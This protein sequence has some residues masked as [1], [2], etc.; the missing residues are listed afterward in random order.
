MKKHRTLISLYIYCTLTTEVLSA[1]SGGMP[2]LNPEFWFS[3]IFWLIITFGL[4]FFVLS[5]FILPNISSNLENRKS[6]ILNNIEKADEQRKESEVKLKEFE[7]IIN[8]SKVQAKNI[9]NDTKKKIS[10][11][12]NNKKKLLEEEINSEIVSMEKEINELKKRSPETINQIAVSTSSDLLKQI[13]GADVNKSNISAIV[14]D[15]SK[16]EK[17]RY[18]GI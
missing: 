10:N 7:K 13:I 5:K 11:E 17:E 3:Q 1:D 14:E 16:K 18:Y 6:Q 12:I 9:I 15:L 8:D 2:Q 4:L